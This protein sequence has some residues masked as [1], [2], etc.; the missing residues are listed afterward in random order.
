LRAEGAPSLR[1]VTAGQR[2]TQNHITLDGLTLASGTVP[3]DAVRSTRVVT[4]TYDVAKGQFSGGEVASTTRSGTNAIQSSL[5]YDGQ[6]SAL[7][8]GAAPSTAYSRQYSLNRLSGSAGGPLVKDRL[9]V[10]GA[11]E[12]S[13]RINPLATLLVSD[14]ETDAR[15]GIAPDSVLNFL[16]TVSSLGI[17]L[18]PPGIPTDQ[19]QERASFLGRMDWVVN[20]T[21][22]I[23]L[24]EDWSGSRGTGTRG[25][26]RALLQNVGHNTRSNS[27]VL[28]GLTSQIGSFTNDIRATV[29]F[30]SRDERGYVALPRGRVFISSAPGKRMINSSP[31]TR[32]TVTEASSA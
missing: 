18:N 13:R 28:A 1:Q 4:S 26:P 12:L 31:P 6:P 25:S 8:V 30:S 29:Q 7:Q 27:G 14:P 11:A 17:P 10:F 32:P 24:R 3:R 15:L 2:P 5:T 23:T 16:S 21:N 9:F 19:T 22:H 20:E